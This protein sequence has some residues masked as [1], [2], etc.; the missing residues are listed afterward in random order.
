MGLFTKDVPLDTRLVALIHPDSGAARKQVARQQEAILSGCDQ[1]EIRSI[2][3]MVAAIHEPSAVVAVVTEARLLVF[4][5]GTLER[6]VDLAQVSDAALLPGNYGG[7][8][9]TAKPDLD[10]GFTNFDDAN[11]FLVRLDRRDIPRLY[12]DFYERILTA[13]GYPLTP[14]NMVRLAERVAQMIHTAGAYAYFDSVQDATAR[15]KFDARFNN[16]S[17]D[18]QLLILSDEMIDWLWAWHAN[19]HTATRGL[20]RETE[21][22]LSA[23]N[24]PLRQN[25]STGLIP[26]LAERGISRRA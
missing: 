22:L 3:T 16:S 23:P 6:H 12:P 1:D 18:E 17:T 10:F 21:E 25:S 7:V 4:R 19:C 14:E 20:V 11:K 24:C 2:K 13:L 5:G 15:S 26:S 8:R 9:A